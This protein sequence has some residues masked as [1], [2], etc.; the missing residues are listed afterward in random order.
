MYEYSIRHV[1]KWNNEI[2]V[3]NEMA[4]QGYRLVAACP[5]DCGTSL[6]FEREKQKEVS[7]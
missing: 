7:K 1:N 4:E 5:Y 3:I 6:Y 2:K